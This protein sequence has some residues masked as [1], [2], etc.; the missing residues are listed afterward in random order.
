MSDIL[1][2]V[3]NVSKKFCRRLKR[4]LW[5]GFKDLG[6][7]LIGRSNGHKSLRKNEFWAL[8]DIS[9][10]L[11]RGESLG[12]IGSNGAG[13]STLLKILNGL[14]RFRSYLAVHLASIITG[15]SQCLLDIDGRQLK[16]GR[17]SVHH[18]A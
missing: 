17:S 18:S 3:E 6:S 14:T 9:F 11:R 8:K 2:Q 13:K 1:I 12:L 15:I 4:S 10:Q 16:S 5:Y 7:E